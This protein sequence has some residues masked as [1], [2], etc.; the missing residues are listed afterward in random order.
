MYDPTELVNLFYSVPGTRFITTR[1]IRV[2]SDLGGKIKTN[3]IL[4]KGEAYIFR[5]YG[6]FIIN[7]SFRRLTSNPKS[8]TKQVFAY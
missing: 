8:A 5:I 7:V 4:I 1:F 2:T 3:L 6:P